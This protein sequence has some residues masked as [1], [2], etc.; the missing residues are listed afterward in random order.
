LGFCFGEAKQPCAWNLHHFMRYASGKNGSVRPVPVGL[1]KPLPS[2]FCSY[3]RV[4]RG[5]MEVS[6]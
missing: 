5:Q 3:C 1:K 2:D 6:V 4:A